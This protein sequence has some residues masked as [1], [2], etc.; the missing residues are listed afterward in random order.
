MDRKSKSKFFLKN[1]V[2]IDS[3]GIFI[4]SSEK[5]F[6]IDLLRSSRAFRIK[7]QAVSAVKQSLEIFKMSGDYDSY[8]FNYAGKK[9]ILKINE[10]S[11]PAV[12]Q[13]EFDALNI[14]Y[15]KGICPKPVVFFTK[16][17][18]SILI[19]S[20]ENGESYQS[21]G[22]DSFLYN[23]EGFAKH[24]S[25]M[26]ETLFDEKF[27][28]TKEYFEYIIDTSDFEKFLSSENM[29]TLN[30]DP[31]FVGYQKLKEELISDLK[32]FL[33]NYENKKV[34]LC[35]LDLKPTNILLRD[36]FFKICNFKES[37]KTDPIFDVIV[38]VTQNDLQGESKTSFIKT[39][40]DS[41]DSEKPSYEE[42]L[43]NYKSL[44][45]IYL[46]LFLLKKLNDRFYE[47]ALYEIDRP[48]KYLTWIEN[49]ESIELWVKENV[50]D[51]SDL[52]E[53]IFYVY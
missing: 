30:S 15:N 50:G 31:L 32:K 40:Y 43:E 3:D 12:L 38:A 28:Q 24:L 1:K 2:F 21:L 37:Y 47:Q 44:E 14:F 19:T 20:Y 42:F 25:F 41:F 9:Y 22:R 45:N 8:T 7:F 39:Y 33:N 23:L 10:N 17:E 29:S 51:Y 52:I 53:N 6:L 13:K 11:N 48:S 36:G 27:D 4:S 26:H 49:Y 16:D 46:K 34:S 35:H 5:D 18:C